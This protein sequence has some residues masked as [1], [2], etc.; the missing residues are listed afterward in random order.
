MFVSLIATPSAVSDPRPV[1]GTLDVR[2]GKDAT[3]APGDARVGDERGY[4]TMDAAERGLVAWVRANGGTA[5]LYA[6]GSME[7]TPGGPFTLHQFAKYDAEGRASSFTLDG[8]RAL[9]VQ[10]IFL[11]AVASATKEGVRL[12]RTYNRLGRV[13]L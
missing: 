6:G 8:V 3:F 2:Y 5:G 11:S 12:V 7:P 13:E 1:T 4:P 10:D 9:D